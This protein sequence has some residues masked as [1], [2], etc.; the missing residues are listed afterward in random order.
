M[1]DSQNPDE[2]DGIVDASEAEEYTT[3]LAGMALAE[4]QVPTDLMYGI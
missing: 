2:R 3:A 4:L 1:A